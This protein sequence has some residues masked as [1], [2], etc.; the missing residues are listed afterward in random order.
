VCVLLYA[1][2][3]CPGRSSPRWLWSTAPKQNRGLCVDLISPATTMGEVKTASYPSGFPWKKRHDS[4][5]PHLVPGLVQFAGSSNFVAMTWRILCGSPRPGTAIRVPQLSPKARINPDLSALSLS[6]HRTS[7]HFTTALNA[8]DESSW[9]QPHNVSPDEL[10]DEPR[11]ILP[12]ELPGQGYVRPLS[13]AAQIS[14]R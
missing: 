10:R 1:T 13:P 2:R 4:I 12:D 11:N 3:F 9:W 6:S 5:T 7:L 8:Q 14:V